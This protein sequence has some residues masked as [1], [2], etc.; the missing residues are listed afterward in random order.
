ME[1]K[2]KIQ[3]LKC[4]GCANTVKSKLEK[5]AGI[6]S[7][8]IDVTNSELTFK[9]VLEEQYDSVLVS[10]KS[11]GYPLVGQENTLSSIA[12][13]YVSCAIGKMQKNE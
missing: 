1:A 5:L 4:G 10:L 7:V 3:N 13:S 12:K 6:E 9:Y 2:F 11:I 8:S